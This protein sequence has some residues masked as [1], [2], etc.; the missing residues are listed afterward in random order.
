MKVKRAI[1]VLALL[2]FFSGCAGAQVVTFRGN[3]G[4]NF[5]W[6]QTAVAAR[7]VN[8]IMP[9]SAS[10]GTVSYTGTVAGAFTFTMNFQAATV[11]PLSP[12]LSGLNITQNLFYWRLPN[13]VNSAQTAI[14]GAIN[15]SLPSL[16][17]IS[18][19]FNAPSTG[20]LQVVLTNASS[21][22]N[23]TLNVFISSGA[24]PFSNLSA[25]AAQPPSITDTEN[26]SAVANPQTVTIVGQPG[27]RTYIYSFNVRCSAG[28]ASVAIKN[29]VGGTV[30]WSTAAADVS[31]TAL[32]RSFPIPLVTNVGNGTDVVVTSCGAG[33]TSTIDVQVSQF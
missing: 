22:V 18:Y 26:T 14:G 15:D 1:S 17:S 27:Q 31:T 4:Q 11:V 8:V 30:M 12:A 9:A 16:G 21:T 28:T 29:G 23:T 25:G 2:L 24:S 5:L 33:N 3:L 13:S 6:Q 7:T 10:W 32:F 19:G 20:V